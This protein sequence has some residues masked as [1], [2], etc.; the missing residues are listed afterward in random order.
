MRSSLLPLFRCPTC[1]SAQLH[2]IGES[3]TASDDL[4]EGTLRCDGCGAAFSVRDGIPRF[5]PATNY[6][7]SFGFQWNKYAKTQLDSYS[8]LEI[9]HDRVFGVTGWQVK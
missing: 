7:D 4:R 2:P 9:S 1:R 8:G 5:V 6:A 3:E